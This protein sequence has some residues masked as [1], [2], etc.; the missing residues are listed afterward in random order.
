MPHF[1]RKTCLFLVAVLLVLACAAAL[2][3]R[4]GGTDATGTCEVRNTRKITDMTGRR[5]SV[6][7]RPQR[8]LSLCTATT[9]TLV[10]IGTGGRIAAVDEYSHAIPGAESAAVVGKAGAL[11]REQVLARRIDLAFV[12]WFSDDVAARLAELGVPVVRIKQPR[13]PGVPEM[14]RLIGECTGERAAGEREAG[15]VAEFLATVAKSAP[16]AQ[17]PTVYLELYGAGKTVGVDSYMSDL[18]ELAGGENVVREN[19]GGMTFSP[20]ALITADPAFILTVE[21]FA[22]AAEIAARPGM[23]G[24]S[25]V[26]TG[27]VRAIPRRLLV[28]GPSLPEAVIAIQQ[29]LS[30]KKQTKKESGNAVPSHH[31]Q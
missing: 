3:P 31:V 24:L 16:P 6:P 19:R 23:A 18:L 26:K 10:A 1:D 28:S 4:T 5:V 29:I 11:S 21:G 17:R 7:V 25:A 20:E 2:W 13:A 22:T 30:E 14:I 8:I 9:D 12:W 27:R 15:R